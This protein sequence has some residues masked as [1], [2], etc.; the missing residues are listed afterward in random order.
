MHRRSLAA[1]AAAALA[2]LAFAAPA[3]SAPTNDN[4]ADARVLSPLPF[5]DDL[6]LG[7]AGTEPGE[8]QAC[9]FQSQTVWY[10]LTPSSLQ[11]LRADLNGSDFGVVF[12]VYRAFSPGFGGLSFLGCIGFG[13]SLDITA[14]PGTTYYIQAGSVSPGPSHLRLNVALRPPPTNDDFASARVV[15]SLPYFDAG[16]TTLATVETDEPTMPSGAWTPI[17]GSVWYRFAPP[18]DGHY[19]FNVNGSFS[20]ILAAYTGTLG[21]LS[22]VAAVSDFSRLTFRANAGTTYMIQVGRGFLFGGSGTYSLNVQRTPPPNVFFFWFPSDVS[23]YD[24]VQ[25]VDSVFDPV[26]AGIASWQWDLGDG[27][28]SDV[29]C[30]QHR[31]AA[32]G[33]YTVTLTVTTRDGRTGSASRVISVRTHD[34][35]IEKLIAPQSAKVGQTR[36]IVV[37]ISNRRYAESAVVTLYRAQPGQFEQYFPVGSATVDIPVDGT[38]RLASVSI[39]YTF[40][41]DDGALGKATFKVTVSIVGARD[42]VPADNTAISLPTKIKP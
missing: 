9:N 14:E 1:F 37:G 20:P 5:T 7:G 33:D 41:A 15:G 31:Y 24:T 40:T 36:D 42:A 34:I 12:N 29:C 19:T 28:T 11:A 25:F 18:E 27:T 3:L 2:A 4:F 8:P 17:L 13:G 10:T 39:P 6:D 26:V 35:A 21:S 23:T 16:D 38:G 22:Q 32:D 30:P